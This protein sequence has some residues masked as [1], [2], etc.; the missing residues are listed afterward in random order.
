MAKPTTRAE[1]KDHIMR[2]LGFPVIEINVDD[3]QVEDRIDEAL[4][5]Y[6]DYHFDGAEKVYYKVLLT[7]TDIDNQYVTLPEGIEVVSIMNPPFGVSG[8]MFNVQYQYVLNNLSEIV[9]GTVSNFVMGMTNLRNMEDLLEGWPHVS[10]NRHTDR[11]YIHEDWTKW[12]VGDYLVVEGYKRLDVDVYSDIWTD[13]WLQNYAAAKV[14]ET[15]GRNLSKFS[16]M[17]LPGGVTFNGEQILNDAR[18]EIRRLEEELL[19]SYSIPVG[20]F[21]G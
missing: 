10:F 4:E 5:Y 9:S 1:F 3:D 6:Y 17:Q 21:I 20:L 8:G 7:Q 11:L 15:W 16:G 2:K 18:E 19:K 12:N 14:Q 13:R